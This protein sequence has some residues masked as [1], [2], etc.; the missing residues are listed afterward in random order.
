MKKRN[1]WMILLIALMLSTGLLAGCGNE[2]PSAIGIVDMQ[3]VM[4]ENGKIKE[5]QDQLNKKAQEITAQLEK[6]RPTLKPEEFQQKEHSSLAFS[7]S[8]RVHRATYHVSPFQGNQER[9]RSAQENPS[10]CCAPTDS[11]MLPALS[12]R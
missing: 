10:G 2:K 4:T 9:H 6:E 1:Q 8:S 11:R 7:P 5:M 12:A 3:K